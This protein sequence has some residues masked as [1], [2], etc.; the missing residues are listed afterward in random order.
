MDGRCKR[1]G[2]PFIAPS[3]LGKVAQKARLALSQHVGAVEFQRG[4]ALLEVGSRLAIGCG[5]PS[6]L[7]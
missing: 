6:T 2:L 4:R 7:R 5:P 3:L 1:I